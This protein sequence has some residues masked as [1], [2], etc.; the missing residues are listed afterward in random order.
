MI[1]REWSRF[2]RAVRDLTKAL[3]SEPNPEAYAERAITY[4]E[5]AQQKTPP[6]RALLQRAIGD[7]ETALDLLP[8]DPD[9]QRELEA[10]RAHAKP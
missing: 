3:E 2:D 4:R 9:L 1:W 10:T 8:D 5:W 7:F 6:D